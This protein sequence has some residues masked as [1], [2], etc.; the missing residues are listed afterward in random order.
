[1]PP[2]PHLDPGGDLPLSIEPIVGWRVW[3]LQREAGSLV[4]HS[5]SQDTTW[6]TRDA[7]RAR[8]L[9]GRHAD[10]G[11]PDPACSCG[12]Y[13]A[14]SPE[15]LRDAGVF[16]R[17]TCVVGAVAMWGRVVEHHRGARSQLA[18]PA[19][20]RLVCG[21]C[22]AGGRGAV[23]PSFVVDSSHELIAVCLRHQDRSR[24]S[25]LD[26]EAIQQE[27]LDTYG[28]ELMPLARVDRSLKRNV[29]SSD[30]PKDLLVGVV[31]L[32]LK[33]LQF[34]FG[35]VMFLAIGT[36]AM[37]IV[38]G[39]VSVLTG[40]TSEEV[41]RAA[42]S[43]AVPA[44]PSL[45]LEGPATPG[46]VPSSPIR[47]SPPAFSLVCGVGH[48]K[49]VELV[50]CS[51]EADLLG[52]SERSIPE[53]AR[54]DCVGGW[55]AYSRGPDYWVCWTDV[56]DRANVRPWARTTDPFNKEVVKHEHR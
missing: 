47:R 34:A 54:K 5:V 52:I 26:A 21:P 48:G 50:D 53:G 46:H 9:R 56:F 2:F 8:C 49:I 45:D 44:V 22:L 13:A 37:S 39:A 30:H 29:R 3:T 42:P 27:L 51:H 43:V 17:L 20:L 11:V 41:T 14:S 19:R 15:H 16:T 6:L 23:D 38:G 4:L 33:L 18:Y 1:M 32:M 12:I 24:G 10:P 55:T 40:G 25:D 31:T 35:A 7:F 36:A 28:V